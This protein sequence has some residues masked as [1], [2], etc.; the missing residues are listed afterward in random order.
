MLRR[1]LAR[2]GNRTAGSPH[3]FAVAALAAGT[4][5]G[6]ESFA[7]FELRQTTSSQVYEAI[8]KPK[9]QVRLNQSTASE[10][11]LEVLGKGWL[12][13]MP[14]EPRDS[15]QRGKFVGLRGPI[16]AAIVEIAESPTESERWRT[17]LLRM[18]DAQ[19]KV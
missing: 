8:P 1:G 12:D 15:K 6:I 16:E 7:R 10:L 14:F 5:V 17:M 18:S 9:V 4:D 2:I 13:R 3:E 11:L 19:P